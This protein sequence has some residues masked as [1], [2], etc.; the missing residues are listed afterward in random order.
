V[1]RSLLVA[2]LL[3]SLSWQ[4]PSCAQEMGQDAVL[5][6]ATPELQ[7]PN[8][9]ESVVLVLFPREGGPVGVILNRP[10]RLTLKDAFPDEPHL[11]ERTDT[12]YFGGPVRP[13]GL[14]FLFRRNRASEGAFPVL[15]DLYLS[16]NGDLLDSLL[17][18][19]EGGVQRYFLGYSGWAPVQL[20]VEVASGA[21][22]VLPAD[23]QTILKMDPKVM[24]R[25]LLARATAVKT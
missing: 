21:W 15:E 4:L 10:T 14:M 17:G 5:L 16:N 7:D 22:Y 12:V 1:R 23:S 20:E 19:A 11:R 3:V 2:F 9:A 6:I 24:W 25:E 13:G 18:G 8:F